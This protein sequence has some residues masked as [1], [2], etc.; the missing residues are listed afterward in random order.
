MGAF[1]FAHV[2]AVAFP[3]VLTVAVS[4]ISNLKFEISLAFTISGASAAFTLVQ[5]LVR[6]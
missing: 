4:P 1:E 6:A 2:F 5:C 3:L